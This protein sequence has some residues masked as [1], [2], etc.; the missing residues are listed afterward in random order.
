MKKIILL[1][2]L[3]LVSNCKS[4]I[5]NYKSDILE[6]SKISDHVFLHTSFLKTESYGNVPC[7]GI[8]IY[9]EKEAIVF[10]TPA[11]E[12]ASKELI[13]WLQ[14]NLKITVIAVV[15]THFHVDCLGS[16]DSFH[17][18]QIP[19][20]ASNL[21]IDLAKGNNTTLPQIG[22]D[23]IKKF[24]IGDENIIVQYFG[25]GHTKDN[26]VVYFPKDNLLFGGCLIKSL[27]A[28]KGNLNDANTTAWPTTVS[29][30]KNTYP[31]ITTVVPGHGKIG[32]TALLDYTIKLF[33]KTPE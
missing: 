16:L 24:Q 32:S 14:T 30:I 10:D 5:E 8:V 1:F 29:K 2:L 12:K 9:N 26:V 6:I 25:E 27:K 15:P 4:K 18:Q 20:Y 21:T 33:T 23:N 11:N 17:Q 13:N 7:N 31:K 19:S 3:V 28:K 22:F